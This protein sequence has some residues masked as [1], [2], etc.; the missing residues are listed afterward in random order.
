MSFPTREAVL[1][2]MLQTGIEI[3]MPTEDEDGW[4]MFPPYLR[5]IDYLNR[6]EMDPRLM[7]YTTHPAGFGIDA[8]EH[9]RSFPLVAYHEPEM[10]IYDMIRFMTDVYNLNINPHHQHD[11]EFKPISW[12]QFEEATNYKEEMYTA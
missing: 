12:L 9:S 4:I 11:P 10:M 2:A 5:Y 8:G 1:K 3:K 7:L 6:S